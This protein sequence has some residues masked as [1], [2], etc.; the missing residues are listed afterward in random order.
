MKIKLPVF[1][2][3]HRGIKSQYSVVDIVTGLRAGLSEV[4]IS[5]GARYFSF[6]QI[7]AH[8][9]SYWMGTRSLLAPRLKNEYSYTSFPPLGLRALFKGEK[10]IIYNTYRVADI[11]RI[12]FS[13]K[14]C[15]HFKYALHILIIICTHSLLTCGYMV[16]QL[17]VCGYSA[18]TLS[19]ITVH[20]IF[21]WWLPIC[22]C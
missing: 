9:A 18:C 15:K 20:H 1:L 19:C 13:F 14:S 17:L 6:L 12:G 8:P 21:N 22:T 11:V 16:L 7:G 10:W 5:V 3:T 2:I 4:W